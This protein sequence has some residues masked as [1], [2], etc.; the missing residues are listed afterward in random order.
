MVVDALAIPNAPGV[1]EVSRDVLPMLK[2]AT[3]SMTAGQIAAI[4][5]G[6]WG[7]GDQFPATRV[8]GSGSVN[9]TYR[10][11]TPDQGVC[12]LRIPP[13]AA[14]LKRSGA[15]G[16]LV[17][18]GLRRERGVIERL[19][20]RPGLAHLLPITI[21]HDFT[22]KQIDRDWVIQREVRGF[23]ASDLLTRRDVRP[24][25]TDPVWRACG[26]LV[27]DIHATR[28]EHD[29]FGPVSHGMQFQYWIDLVRADVDGLI[30]DA[31]D[32]EALHLALIRLRG[33]VETHAGRLAEV[34]QPTLIHSDLSLHHVF[35]ADAGSGGYRVTGLIDL[36]F[37]RFAD[38]SCEKLFTAMLW[39]GEQQPLTLGVVNEC[40]AMFGDAGD[41][42]RA[43]IYAA[44]ALGWNATLKDC[45][46]DRPEAARLATVI[47]GLCDQLAYGWTSR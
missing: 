5:G 11:T 13:S 1:S 42:T 37:A 8:S 6:V 45:L 4:L 46:G 36:E 27:A 43:T 17:P 22:R 39:L 30:G 10:I 28:V 31:A 29:Q 3:R 25:V 33:L 16:W 40:L 32:H 44:I 15:P 41:R 38:A 26:D 24:E 9:E 18:D 7:D 23:A 21:A 34:R 47:P 35:L 14:D 20:Q 2:P 19:V 12:Y